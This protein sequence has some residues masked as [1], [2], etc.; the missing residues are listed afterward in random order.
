M[1]RTIKAREV[2]PGMEV[3]FTLTRRMKVYK[4]TEGDYS[5]RGL[6]DVSGSIVFV[7]A[8]T[9][10]TVL[11]EAQPEEPTEFGAKVAVDGCPA[12]RVNTRSSE[13]GIWALEPVGQEPLLKTWAAL[14]EMGDMVVPDQGWTV[15]DDTPEVPERIDEWPED[16]TALRPYPWRDREGDTW[17]WAKAQAEWECHDDRNDYLTAGRRP[18]PRFAPFTRVTDA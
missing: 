18:S 12:V 1:T 2:K 17:T 14:L 8:D 10:V 9:P 16:D 7:G 5:E 4:N 15:P 6:E 3:E 11:S 13:T